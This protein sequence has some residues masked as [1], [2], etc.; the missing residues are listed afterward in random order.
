MI[1]YIKNI[2]FGHNSILKNLMAK[3]YKFQNFTNVLFGEEY[4]LFPSVKE[5][6]EL[7]LAYL[8]YKTLYKKDFL[9]RTA[10]FQSV[11]KEYSKHYNLCSQTN[12]NITKV[13]L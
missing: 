4:S 1:V 6:F 9:E 12:K 3:F 10:F 5:L 13:N 8:E 11:N 7:E 2:F